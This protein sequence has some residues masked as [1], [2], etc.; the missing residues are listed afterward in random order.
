MV[1]A[2]KQ[3]CVAPKCFSALFLFFSSLVIFLR[4]LVIPF[5]RFRMRSY[6]SEG[7]DINLREE[8]PE[9][10]RQNARMT[11][12]GVETNSWDLRATVYAP[13]CFFALFSFK[14]GFFSMRMIWMQ[15][16]S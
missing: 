6:R 3:L 4:I 12:N 5:M 10:A 11:E 1:S 16:L 8:E 7:P 14:F 13:K 2:P 15:D 9:F